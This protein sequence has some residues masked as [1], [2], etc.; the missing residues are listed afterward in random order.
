MAA[1]YLKFTSLSIRNF[2][3]IGN[4]TQE[5]PLDSGDSVLIVGVNRDAPHGGGNG[6]GKC[7]VPETIITVRNK[8]SGL[9]ES[10]TIGEF[11]ERCKINKIDEGNR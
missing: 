11:H 9:I 4:Q 1:S 7:V 2:L 6:V 5:L 10:I 8:Y 3:S